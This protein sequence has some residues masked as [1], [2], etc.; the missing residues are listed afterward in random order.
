MGRQEDSNLLLEYM[1]EEGHMKEGMRHKI[2]TPLW[3]AD[4][5]CVLSV[6]LTADPL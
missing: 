4:P 3:E 2:L 1:R 5:S 6:D